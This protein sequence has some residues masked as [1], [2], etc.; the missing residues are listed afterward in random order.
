MLRPVPLRIQGRILEPEIGRQI[1]DGAH[2]LAQI[3]DQLLGRSVGKG[4]EHDVQPVGARRIGRLEEQLRVSGGQAGIEVTDPAPGLGVRGRETD[5][6]VRVPRGQPQQFGAGVA[7]RAEDTDAEGGA[8]DRTLYTSVHN[9]ATDGLT[10]SRLWITRRQDPRKSQ[11]WGSGS[12]QA[13]WSTMA[14]CPSKSPSP[15]TRPN[16][17]TGRTPT[18]SKAHSPRSSATT[19]HGHWIVG[20]S[21]SPATAPNASSASGDW[22]P[23]PERPTGRSVAR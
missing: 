10:G 20:A 11:G 14:P 2:P 7:R 19:D 6:E 4:E 9:H 12:P 23:R 17:S 16:G 22:R 8:H 5:V 3:R 13:G 18:P 21:R 15:M 1:D